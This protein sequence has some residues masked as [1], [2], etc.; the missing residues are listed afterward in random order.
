MK[1]QPAIISIL[2]ILSGIII[3]GPADELSVSSLLNR[4]GSIEP[5][6][7]TVDLQLT[8]D[9]SGMRI[10]RSDQGYYIEKEGM[11]LSLHEGEPVVP[12]EIISA[13][14]DPYA[15]D[16]DLE[17]VGSEHFHAAIPG[18]LARIP[19]FLPIGLPEEDP[20][21]PEIEKIEGPVKPLDSGFI[22]GYRI[23]DLSFTPVVPVSDTEITVYTDVKVSI[24]FKVPVNGDLPRVHGFKRPTSVFE[25]YMN[26]LL[27]NPADLGRFMARPLSS[28]SSHLQADDVQYVIITDSPKIGSYLETLRDWKIAKGVPARIVEMSFIKANYTGKDN[29]EK[30][31][32]FI[33][34]AVTSW[35]TEFVLLGGDVSVVPYR[36]TY[37]AANGYTSTDCAADLYYSDLDRTF[38]EDNDTTYGE[39]TDN[40]DL[41][42]DVI[43]GRAPADTP[44][45]METFVSKTLTY[46]KDPPSGYLDNVTLAGEYLDD[47]TNSSL[48][49]DLI[50]KQLLTANVNATSLYDSAK[51][52][53]GNLNRPAFM[54]KVDQGASYVFHAG[55]SNSNVMSV[56]TAANGMMYNS[57]IYL[58]N[59]GDKIG[60][61]NSVG[62]IANRFSV[63]DCIG[64]LHVMEADGGSVSYIGNSRYGWYA[65]GAPG[66]G[67]S[68]KYQFRMAQELY[69][70]GNTRMGEHFAF[71]KDFYTSNSG[72]YN[73]Y[74]WIQMCLNL[75]GDPEPFVRT[76]EPQDFNITLPPGISRNNS[77]FN[78][79]VK[80]MNGS[81]VR[82]ALVCLQQSGYY[83]YNITDRNGKAQFDFHTEGFEPV[84]ITVTG[85]NF[86]PFT[87]NLSVD[88]KPPKIELLSPK[89]AT[90]GDTYDLRCLVDDEA[91]VDSV[92]A[93]VL[94]KG[95]EVRNATTTALTTYEKNWT[96]A[97]EVPA[98]YSGNFSLRIGARDTPGNWNTTGWFEIEVLDNDEPAVIGDLT[99]GTATT[100][101][102]LTF[103]IWATDNIGMEDV[104]ITYGWEG[105]A[106]ME[107]EPMIRS[108]EDLWNYALPMPEDRI[109]TIGY[110]I[111]ASDL[112]RNINGSHSG[113]VLVLDNDRPRFGTET[114]D[115]FGSTS[116]AMTFSISATDNIGVDTVHVEYW[117]ESELEHHNQTMVK[118]SGTWKYSTLLDPSDLTSFSYI[119]RAVDTSGNWN[120]T[121]G[122]SIPVL[123]DDPPVFKEDLTAGPGRTGNEQ[124][125][126]VSVS[127]NIKVADVY[128]MSS[129][130]FPESMEL[131]EQKEGEWAV[132]TVLPLNSTDP[133]TYSFKAVDQAGNIVS[134][135]GW[136]LEMKDDDVPSFGIPDYILSVNAGEE[137]RVSI[138]V[139]DNIGIARVFLIWWIGG[140]LR[141]TNSTMQADGSGLWIGGGAISREAFGSVYFNVKAFDGEGNV[142]LSDRFEISIIEYVEDSADDDDDDDN[143]RE[144]P[145]SG[146]DS[147]GDGMEDLWEFLHGLNP[148]L[149]DSGEDLD[150]DG[151]TNLEEFLA[152]TDPGDKDSMP[153]EEDAMKDGW[154]DKNL[155]L[156][157]MI[158]SA[159]VIL[160]AAA[161]AGAL[162]HVKRETN[163]DHDEEMVLEEEK[164]APHL[165]HQHEPH[166]QH[167]HPHPV[168]HKPHR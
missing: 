5:P 161:V 118:E 114:S 58:Y 61:M 152:G 151:F 78:L 123:D 74:R 95:Q 62:C 29:Q 144:P 101:E 157:I 117:R 107:K 159:I 138:E 70:R 103:S 143:I 76:A 40:V 88:L 90:T 23:Q 147:D 165:D 120:Q 8:F 38:N 56:G 45:Q 82:N 150:S 142:A 162:L 39:T 46:E 146:A 53:F 97:I 112:S 139:N 7:M 83:G 89:E 17:I 55:H 19:S 72:S 148:L 94:F 31:R 68:E 129:A 98:N 149:D 34:D 96:A 153:E 11:D 36:S 80:D 85:Y 99:P 116:D 13:V 115:V 30:V 111:I 163:Y 113:S 32:N 100:G 20:P 158:A 64:E 92:Q 35:D 130:L 54:G 33:R 73:S 12:M 122:G 81:A 135:P 26:G 49:M 104:S 125:F 27:E 79:T 14:I 67:P 132:T 166:H 77:N 105:I 87:A 140:T 127:D 3:L 119:F 47:N 63:N 52:V 124:E 15:F 41:R 16:I 131:K 136:K 155:L 86:L 110:R 93:E 37:V 156:V 133:V 18:P 50:K 24:R 75:M 102:T 71:A 2:L 145:V 28:G 167:H 168:E 141:E 9:P 21:I 164:K 60:V 48:G 69:M 4:A 160:A 137:F 84:N 6:E 59:G 66:W 65:Y 106:E 128:L 51:G 121:P 1:A 10:L 22:R 126:R 44:S 57:H 43:V 42:P 134:S 25:A 109:G 154:I 108:G 91:G